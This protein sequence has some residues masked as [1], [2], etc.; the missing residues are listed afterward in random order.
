[1]NC[2]G[3][4]RGSK[5]KR[6]TTG[7]FRGPG[8]RGAGCGGAGRGLNRRRPF[9]R[10]LAS[11]VATRRRFSLVAR[12]RPGE[13][14]TPHDA[15]NSNPDRVGSSRSSPP[16][17]SQPP[18]CLLPSRL[19]PF[20]LGPATR[21][22]ATKGSLCAFFLDGWTPSCVTRGAPWGY[23]RKL[24][25]EGAAAAILKSSRSGREGRKKR[26]GKIKGKNSHHAVE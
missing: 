6:G 13:F 24:E 1:V 21:K 15:F 25:G 11:L 20:L 12:P 4:K 18:Y 5:L 23:A 7:S 3:F 9:A 17:T 2:L 22:E 14:A 16:G 26:R 19:P 10:F 8:A